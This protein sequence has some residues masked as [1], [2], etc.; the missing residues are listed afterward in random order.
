MTEGEKVGFLTGKTALVTGGTRGI[1]R[2]CAEA[3]YAEGA[4]VV[5]NGRSPE[6]GAQAAEEMGGGDRVLFLSAGIT[7]EII[8]SATNTWGSA[9]PRESM[10][11]VRQRSN[12]RYYQ[13]ED[14]VAQSRQVLPRVGLGRQGGT[15]YDPENLN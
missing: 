9:P 4:S 5:I 1:G 11:P 15:A 8:R 12:P 3:L 14:R 10:D 6:K 7:E 2:A 13:N